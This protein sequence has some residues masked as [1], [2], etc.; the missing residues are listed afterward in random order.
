MDAQLPGGARPIS[1]VPD[2]SGLDGVGLQVAQL[3]R[4]V[5]RGFHGASRAVGHLGGQ[6][7]DLD[8]RFAAQD[9]G[10]LDEVFQLAD[11]TRKAIADQGGAWPRGR[12]P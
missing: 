7:F 5:A 8:L 12:P 3:Q 9:E 10:P 1:P 6:A 11:V 2:Q 4:G